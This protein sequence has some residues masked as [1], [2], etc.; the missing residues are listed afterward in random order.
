[1]SIKWYI[2]VLI[3]LVTIFLVQQ[4][5]VVVPN[6]EIVVNFSSG[7]VSAEDAQY[8]VELLTQQL[9]DAGVQEIQA[10]LLENG[11]YKISY[12]SELNVAGIKQLINIDTFTA[13]LKDLPQS[14]TLPIEQQSLC[15]LDVYDLLQHTND[16]SDT[17]SALFIEIKQD[18]HR[19]SQVNYSI[20]SMVSSTSLY[21]LVEMDLKGSNQ[22]LG[23]TVVSRAHA[24]PAVRA[25]PLLG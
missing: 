11:R 15:E 5:D 12:H 18:V 6:Q 25:G 10:V 2:G 20:Y 9:L 23:L 3:S 24:I 22:A 21:G 7:V 13:F 4:R 16:I 19:G 1:M 8:S 17:E 14:Q